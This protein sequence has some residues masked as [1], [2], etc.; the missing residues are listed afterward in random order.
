M[1]LCDRLAAGV[2][3]RR[4]LAWCNPE[5]SALITEALGSDDWINN[6]ERLAELRKFANDTAFQ[7]CAEGHIINKF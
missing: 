2:T 3:P 1:T 5:L 7:V 4:W 6:T